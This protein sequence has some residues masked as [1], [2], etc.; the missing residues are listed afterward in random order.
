MPSSHSGDALEKA[1]HHLA[2]GDLQRQQGRFAEAES[3]YRDA[4]EADARFVPAM[5]GLGAVLIDQ[6]RAV[7]A[8]S[9]LER[10]LKDTADPGLLTEL[11]N[12]LALAQK[13]QGKIEQAL[14]N[15]AKAQTLNPARADL[16]INR[17]HMLEDAW[18]F[19]EAAL[20][21]KELLARD[22]LNPVLHEKY[23]HFLYQLGREDEFLESYDRVAKTT[24]LQCGKAMFLLAVKRGQEAHEIYRDIFAR[25]PGN[26]GV[27]MGDA[28]ALNLL[29][30]HDQA[31]RMLEE[32][33]VRYPDDPDLLRALA[34]TALQGRDPQRAAAI[35]QKGASLAPEDQHMLALLG[36]SWRMLG[37]ERDEILNGYEELIGVF[38]LEPPDGFPDMATFN[39]ALEAHLTKLH[40]P[41]REFLMRSL[42]GGT[43][44]VN[45]LFD[46]GHDLVD[47]L[48]TRIAECVDRYI[49]ELPPDSRHPFRRRRRAGFD[50]AGSWSSRLSD[51][52]FHINHIHSG[53]ISSCY[54]V[55]VPKAVE[56]SA[57]KQGWI[58]FG[59]PGYE[60]G[61][62]PR[63]AIQPAP[64]RLVLFPSYMWH[65]TIPF[66]DKSP[67][68]TVA[69]DVVPR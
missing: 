68:V 10:A 65:G 69:F 22:P 57:G 15:L 11:A 39:A 7:E 67:R 28:V 26:R 24:P 9:L 16:A 37:D 41:T 2:Q 18:R 20:V 32:M 36:T 34:G 27:V 59:E 51:C 66:H 62:A 8:E 45:N 46:A 44:T 42:R 14:E 54:Y 5:L 21:M 33:L 64:G 60:L 52:G 48:K 63:R 19:D 61:I 6:A 43:Q 13:I 56:D 29:G 53:W 50:F 23:N 40:P 35:A 49:K 1:A 4:L 55:G 30:R 58:K 17:A 31:A 3:S 25:E 38:D 12:H 47:R